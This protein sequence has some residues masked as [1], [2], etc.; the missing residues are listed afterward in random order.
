MRFPKIWEGLNPPQPPPLV[1]YATDILIH[2]EYIIDKDNVGTAVIIPHPSAVENKR[3][4]SVNVT[5]SAT[6]DEYRLPQVSDGG[7]N[8]TVSYSLWIGSN[9]TEKRSINITADHNVTFYEIMQRASDLDS[10]FT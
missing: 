10:A 5:G 8:V 1:G 7:T 6:T 3:P 2:G 9:I 4:V